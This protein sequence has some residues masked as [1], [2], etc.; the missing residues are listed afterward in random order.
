MNIANEMI[1]EVLMDVPAGHRHIRARIILQDNTE[2][3]FQEATIANI[4]RAYITLK[5]HPQT[6]S[7][8]LSGQH[9]ENRKQGFADWQLI[10]E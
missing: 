6:E 10:E 3:V 5:T 2:I 4:S 1:K 7:V 9:L 8:R